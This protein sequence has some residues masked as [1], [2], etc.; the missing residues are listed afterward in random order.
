MRGE[1]IEFYTFG[2]TKSAKDLD[3]KQAEE[4]F[5]LI[6]KIRRDQFMIRYDEQG[7]LY[8][9]AANGKAYR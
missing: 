9:E 7:K 6:N 5:Q 2:E 1:L 3:E 8:L 4:L